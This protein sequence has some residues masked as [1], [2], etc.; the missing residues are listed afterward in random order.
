[1]I[2][3]KSQRGKGRTGPRTA[4]G[5]RRSALN[6]LK[7]GLCPGWVEQQL[8]ARGENPEDFRR[9][10]RDLIGYLRPDDARSRVM[11]ETLAETWWEKMRL[12]RGWV[13]AG[14]CDTKEIDARIDGLVQRLV[15]AMRHRHRKWRYRLESELGKG[16]YAPAVVRIRLESLVRVLGGKPPVRRGVR[17]GRDRMREFKEKLAGLTELLSAVPRQSFAEKDAVSQ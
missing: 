4:R 17:Q 3:V 6:R 5:K 14:R 7:R 1:M 11:V 10:H 12:L 8:R 9:L 16:L 13:G 2:K 15:W